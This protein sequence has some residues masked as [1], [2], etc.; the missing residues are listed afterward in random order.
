MLD[1]GGGDNLDNDD[2]IGAMEAAPMIDDNTEP[3]PEN[4]PSTEDSPGTP[5]TTSWACG[6]TAAFA[7]RKQ[8]SNT[9]PSQNLLSGL[10]YCPTH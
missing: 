5:P 3:A 7:S 10:C 9:M 2:I 1:F 8:Q 6:P 4:L